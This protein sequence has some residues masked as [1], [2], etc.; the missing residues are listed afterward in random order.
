MARVNISVKNV[1]TRAVLEEIERQTDY[2]F[3]FSPEEINMEKSTSVEAKNEPVAQALAALFRNTDI[4]YAMEG[5]N[6]FLF[7]G[8]EAKAGKTRLTQAG[9]ITVRG[10][11]LEKSGEPVAGANVI[12]KGTTN[13][14]ISDIDGAF[15]LNVDPN[16]ILQVSYLG[17][18]PME[19]AVNNR[20][21]ITVT[22]TEDTKALEEV[23]VIGYG[24][25]T[26]KDL[27]GAVS[28][29]NSEE[30]TRQVNISPQFAMQGKMAGIL[31]SNPGSS[32][33][34]RP[35]VRIRGVSTLGYNDPLYVIDGIPLTEGDASNTSA[36]ASD[37]RGSVNVFTMINPNDIESIS[38]LK[39]ASATAIYGVRASNGVIL[40]TTKRGTEGKPKVDFSVNYGIQNIFKRYD[41]ASMQETLDMSLEAMNA[42]TT[43][44]KDYW[45][46]VYD[47]TSAYYAGNSKDYSKEWMDALLNKNAAIQDYNIS[48]SGGLKASTYAV[49]AG[50]SNQDDVIFKDGFQRYSLFMNSDHNLTSW[51]KLGESYRFIYTKFEDHISPSFRDISL[52]L[53]WQPLY[54]PAGPDG[55]AVPGRDIDGTFR[56]YGYGPAT[57]NNFLGTD[58]HTVNQRKMIRN[59]GTVYAEI[60]PFEG[61]R[62]RGTFSFDYYTNNLETYT[63]IENGLFSI[64]R[65]TVLPEGNT[66]NLRERDNINLVKEFLIAYANK[67]GKHSVDLVLN[68]MH[69]DIKFNSLQ[70]SIDRNSPIPS[71]DQAY[72]NEGW[73][74]EDK[75]L[76][77]TRNAS[78]L[79]GYMGR[80]S[81]HFDSKYYLDATIRR[82]GSSKFGPGYKW[83]TFPSFAGAW[84]MSSESFMR[85]IPWLNDLKLRGGWGQS[86]N[87]ETRD[88]AFLSIVNF[89]PKAAFGSD[90]AVAGDGT[91]YPA[92][93]LGDFPVVDMSWE[94][95]STFSV[96][97]DLIAL[98]NKL[99][100]TAEYYN[101]KTDGI[102]QGIVIPWT[103]GAL[104]SP[105]INLAKVDNRGIELQ[106]GYNDRFGDVGFNAAANFTTVRN[107]VYNLFRDQPQGSGNTRIESGYTMNYLYGYKTDGIFQTDAEVAAYKE[108]TEDV[109]Y[110]SQKSPGDVHYVDL[111]GA[112][113]E[114]D[115]EGALK[116]YEPDGKINDYD[117]TYLGKTIPG[118]YYG[119]TLGAD[120]K[121]WDIVLGFRGVGDVQKEVTFGL[122]PTGV[123]QRYLARY[124][125]SWTPENHSNTIPRL[126]QG[127]P[128]GNDRFSSRHVQDAD[129]FRFQ[130]FQIGYRFKGDWLNKAGINNLRCYVSGS[131]LFVISSY[132]DLDPENITTPTVFSIGA[133]VSF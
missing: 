65:G 123:E 35:E 45:Y 59:L 79:L 110:D 7:K 21:H 116:H 55:L 14:I 2:L 106:A 50:Y 24:S 128:S 12:E 8:K 13:G 23:V 67:F 9:K 39:D 30:I 91:I 130:N 60:S 29:I 86:G 84:R 15:I 51:L 68:A 121:N 97:F 92:A 125:D 127:D 32:P 105:V 34:S 99:N 1:K 43:Y 112:P 28:H 10:V 74:S 71:W 109:G 46:P 41:V 100:F 42:N 70:A 108:K 89:N 98:H 132:N 83:G 57:Q 61:L 69:Q 107:R 52:I 88:Y 38:V 124:R 49:G 81:Y 27:T 120:Y 102:L 90:P 72:I 122:N 85:D 31:I 111:Y 77:Y 54:D 113:T 5:Y 6:I 48:I 33:V 75:G 126:I 82:D 25:R 11:V 103:I 56:G 62:F 80:L 44:T 114:A 4:S 66:F 93:V 73:P 3:L 36:G 133:N 47:R 63:E 115:R 87:Q 95:V 18:I 118:Y 76:F 58:K 22:L 117:K 119:I 64:A 104:N 40:I 16:A 19:V 129:F 96:G 20:Q 17:Y 78:G 131:N 26:K 101:R 37:F 94:T 53:P